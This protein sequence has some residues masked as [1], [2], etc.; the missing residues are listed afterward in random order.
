MTTS[1]ARRLIVVY[2]ALL[3]LFDLSVLLPGNPVSSFGESVGAVA[4]QMLIVW[5][6]WHGSTISWVLAL[7]FAVGYVVSTLGFG[8]SLE[9]GFILTVVLAITQAAILFYLYVYARARPVSWPERTPPVP[10]R[11]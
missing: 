11:Q 3:A 8:L 1:P 7:A 9:V 4:V 10:L 2:A 5:R 6:L